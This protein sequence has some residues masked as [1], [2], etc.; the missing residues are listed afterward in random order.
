MYVC[1]TVLSSV[2]GVHHLI[3][4]VRPSM[5]VC[6][7][8]LYVQ[9]TGSFLSRHCS[10]ETQCWDQLWTIV[11]YVFSSMSAHVN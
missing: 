9:C 4:I 5:L 11:V 1:K 10:A 2:L 6:V 7:Y 8:I 3:G